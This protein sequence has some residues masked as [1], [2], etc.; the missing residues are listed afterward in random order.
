MMDTTKIKE[1]MEVVG[2]DNQHVGTVDEMEGQDRIKLTK[3]DPSSG[4][5]HHWISMKDVE[6][7]DDK[8]HMRMPASQVQQT[9]ASM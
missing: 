6:R 5:T 2:S 3:S 8:V 4:G 7:I 9:A 1:H